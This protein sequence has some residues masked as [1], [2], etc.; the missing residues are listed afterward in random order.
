MH[1][2]NATPLALVG[3]THQLPD[4]AHEAHP[5]G[6]DQGQQAATKRGPNPDKDLA[7]GDEIDGGGDEHGGACCRDDRH[8]HRRVARGNGTAVGSTATATSVSASPFA[9]AAAP[10]GERRRPPR[11]FVTAT[12]LRSLLA[13][14][15]AL[16]WC[17][18]R[19]SK[20]MELSNARAAQVERL[21]LG[22]LA[23]DVDVEL[24][25]LLVVLLAIVDM[26]LPLTG[27]C[28]EN[29][30]L[31]YPRSRA[32]MDVRSVYY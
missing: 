1:M 20:H 32:K 25:D 9:V 29:L 23:A 27:R 13:V 15:S 21:K 2:G 17:G 8:R 14:P 6:I 4:K 28:N 24:R 16:V 10:G 7:P 31:D 12:A 18:R 22:K 5:R 19:A 26:M 11:S 30:A 3:H